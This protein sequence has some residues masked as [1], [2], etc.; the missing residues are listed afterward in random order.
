[1]IIDFFETSNTL[2]S[3]EERIQILNSLAE[4][5]VQSEDY[6]K[7]GYDYFDNPEHGVGYGGYKYDGRYKAAAKKMID[8][9]KLN[10]G[11]R[12]LEV[13]CAKGY[14]LIEFHKLG[15]EVYG[16]DASDYAVQNAHPDIKDKI[17]LGDAKN[18]PF[19]DN[20]FSFAFGKEVLPHIEENSVKVVINECLRVSKG[21]IF[22]EIGCGSTEEEIERMKAWDLT[23]TCV[24]TSNW[25]ENKFKEIGSDKCDRHYKIL[26]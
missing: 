21:K 19:D 18:L 6:L 10:P 1:M 14:I 4:K 5:N 15:L 12:V 3:R 13:G 11:D 7:Y 25:W 9:Y 24:K 20:F 8:H 16:V 2:R 22:F 17:Q 26:L 23:Q